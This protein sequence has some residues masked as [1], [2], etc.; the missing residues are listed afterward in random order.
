MSF[1]IPSSTDLTCM[2]PQIQSLRSPL[3]PSVVFSNVPSDSSL[4]FDEPYLALLSKMVPYAKNPA[5]LQGCAMHF[6]KRQFVRDEAIEREGE[7]IQY[8]FWILEGTCSLTHQVPF[9]QSSDQLGNSVLAVPSPQSSPDPAAMSGQL[10]TIPVE[11]QCLRAGEW[12]PHL[13]LEDTSSIPDCELK[14]VLTRHD[15]LRNTMTVVASSATVEVACIPLV[16]FV[17]LAS[18]AVLRDLIHASTAHHFDLAFLAQ[19]FIEQ[20]SH[21]ELCQH[22][23]T[24]LAITTEN[25]LSN[26]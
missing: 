2:S 25:S 20:Q 18:D 23:Q 15:A 8:L 21:K 26:T 7:A 16:E 11:T 14:P 22:V 17:A 1:P 12:F 19:E 5:L 4:T 3:S 13:A 9:V 10:I 24:S 6:C